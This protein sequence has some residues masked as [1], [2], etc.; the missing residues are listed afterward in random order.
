MEGPKVRG[1]WLTLFRAGVDLRFE[2]V[3]VIFLHAFQLHAR[4][5]VSSRLSQPHASRRHA[6]HAFSS[7]VAAHRKLFHALS[8][9]ARD[10]GFEDAEV[11]QLH[12]VAVERNLLDA[13]CHVVDQAKNLS[14]A[15]RAVV[16]AHV[17]SQP[18]CVYRL[19]VHGPCIDLA[20]K[21]V[22][23][24]GFVKCII[25]HDGCKY[26]VK[27]VDAVSL[28]LPLSSSSSFLFFF[29]PLLLLS[30]SSFLFFFQ[31]LL[32]ASSFSFLFSSS[33][34]SFSFIF[35]FS[36]S[37]LSSFSFHLSSISRPSF[38]TC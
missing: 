9:Q 4:R 21:L 20:V 26:L 19:R 32:L 3:L 15:V 38:M 29:F 16:L 24:I 8:G 11:R 33:S 37:S 22:L 31:L 34:F 6:D 12:G 14:L 27:H 30:S 1:L 36:S 25:N 17:F 35:F 28:P 13:G 2:R 7:Y 23:S 10:G 5:L 18:L